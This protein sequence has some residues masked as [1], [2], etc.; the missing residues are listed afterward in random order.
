MLLPII[1]ATAMLLTIDDDA[2]RWIDN[3]AVVGSTMTTMTVSLVLIDFSVCCSSIV[4]AIFLRLLPLLIDDD[5]IA[6][7]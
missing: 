2:V 6:D 7:R 4:I 5:A 1:D 3:D